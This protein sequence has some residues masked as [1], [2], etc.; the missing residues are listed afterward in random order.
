MKED[1]LID[2]HIH[3]TYSDGEL[4]PH[5]LLEYSSDKNISII[6]ITDHDTIL[7]AK[8]A[9][10]NNNFSNIKIIPGIELGA[11]FKGGQLHILG[12]GISLNDPNL[13]FITE[14]IRKDNI[15]RIR[16]IIEQLMKYK[17]IN[18]HNSDLEKIYFSSGSVGRPDIAKLMVKYGHVRTVKDAFTIF[19]EV[20]KYK[21]KIELT[22]YECI[23]YIIQAGGI[24]SLAHNITL[25]RDIDWIEKYVY[26]LASYG[27]EAIEAYHSSHDAIYTQRTL[28][29]AEKLGLFVS[30]GSDYHGPIVKPDVQLGTGKNNNLH[31]TELS[32][33]DELKRRIK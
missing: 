3:S 10:N 1:N 8:E 7:G 4:T 2:M 9:I 33:I 28:R 5:E 26:T 22:D 24:A 13:N 15:D 32:I 21:K 18:F 31:I 16:F 19:N 23:K 14:L 29:I 6:S 12:Y 20:P 17:N 30:G 25:K 27:L 11:Q